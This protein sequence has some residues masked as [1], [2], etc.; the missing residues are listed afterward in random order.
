M[1]SLK[2]SY[3]YLA[4]AGILYLA[5]GCS[6]EKNTASTRFYHGMTA[7]YNI[8]FN[9]YESFREGVIKVNNSYR[10]DYAELLK[11]FEFSDPS[12]ASLCASDMERAIQKA[13]KLISLKSITARPEVKKGGKTEPDTDLLDRKEYNEWVDDS[14]LLIGKAR[15]YKR[16]FTEAEAVLNY[17]ITTANDPAVR[18]EASI[19][20]SRLFNETSRPDEALKLLSGLGITDDSPRLMRSMYYSTLADIHIREKKYTE[21]IAPLERAVSL[22]SGKRSKYR[23]TYLLAQLNELAGN[24]SEAISLYRD[25]VKM[26]PPYDVEFNARINI[27]GVF[28]V[29]SGN[30]EEISRELGKMLRD[31]KNKDYLDQIYYA[32]GSLSMKEGK[33]DEATGYYSKSASASTTNS[34]QK[35]RSYLA[36]AEYYYG[37]P[38]FMKAGLY[39]DSTVIFLSQKHPGYQEIKTRSTDLNSVV[40]HLKVIQEQDSLQR[41]A[42]MSESDRNA[43]ISLIINDIS[44]A[45]SEGKVSEYASRYSMGQYYE[46]EQRF[47]ENIQQEG[48]WYFYNQSAL[49]FG[50]SEFRR[51]WGDR[52]LEDNWRRFNKARTSITQPGVSAEEAETAGKDTAGA[53]NDYKRPEFYLKNLPLTDS[54]LAASNE[55]ITNAYLNAGKAYYEK[56]ADTP[57]ATESL[58]KLISRFPSDELVPE[59]LYNLH[60]FNKDKNPTTGEAYRQRLLEKYPETEFS[61]ILSD[62]DYYAKKMADLKT[63]E[64]VYEKAYDSYLREDFISAI[65]K[66]DSALNVFRENQLAPKFMLLRAYAVARI[67]DEK[68]FKE[69][70]AKIVKNWPASEESKKASEMMAYLN[71]KIPELKV[72]ED[73]EIA[74]ELYVPDTLS[75]HFFVIIIENPKFNINQGAFDVISYN[76]DNFTNNNYRTQ[77][78]LV[79]NKFIMITVS[80]FAKFR[81][82]M[83]YYRAFDVQKIVRNPSASRIY[84]FLISSNNLKAFR[85]DLNPE[86]YRLFYIENYLNETDQNTVDR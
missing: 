52:P 3:K 78:E 4:F 19:W 31:S 30:P 60:R 32:L 66:C 48:K 82:S 46:N 54:L 79:D 8:Y 12:T 69:E 85:E 27:A 50:R 61:K 51:R 5:S 84:S 23:M 58:E 13:S 70:L 59:A 14:Y 34:N 86:R 73:K 76:I 49:T 81:Q 83:D 80:G 71:Q 72:E 29:Q 75:A 11:V 57:R 10:D 7:R 33:I 63:A 68:A 47:R 77:G 25:V 39:Y 1:P 17:S 43:L 37:K 6:V 26:N 38:D 67:D 64:A 21:A 15:F 45:E 40:S 24:A 22:T 74:R 9:G 55:K 2:A 44:K 62:P 53:V 42:A 36:L 16:E 56:L 41:V 35:G 28:D 65:S 20:L 18:E